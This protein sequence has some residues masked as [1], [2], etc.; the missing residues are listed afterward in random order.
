MAEIELKLTAPVDRLP[1]L[2]AAL[3][4]MSGG[5]T[6]APEALHATYYDTRARDL[7]RQ[8][9]TLRVRRESGGFVQTVKS[10]GRT[11]TKRGEWSDPL[12][13]G[14][15]DLKA[16]ATGRRLRNVLR[17]RVLPQFK[18][19][20]SRTAFIIHAG[21]DTTI[22]A[23]V[24]EGII[25]G[26]GKNAAHDRV[27]EV[28]LELKSGD[29]AALYTTALKLMAIAPLA[30][31]TRSKS[32]RG[33]AL[34]ENET[35]KWMKITPFAID[36]KMSVDDV[37][38]KA[39]LNYLTQC[40]KNTPAVLAD[41][42]EGIHQMRVA[43]RRLRGLLNALKKELPEAAHDWANGRLK[44][45]LQS[46]GPARNWDVFVDEMVGAVAE[47]GALSN[48]SAFLRAANIARMRAHLHARDAIASPAHTTAILELLRWF[49]IR[50]WRDHG[51]ASPSL[52]RRIGKS[53]G[54]LVDRQ[55]RRART[56]GKG[57]EKLSTE[58]RHAFRIAVKSLRY[59]L[60]LFCP[61]LDAKKVRALIKT[62]KPLQE[63]LGHLND[64]ST[65]RELLRDLTQQDASPNVTLVGGVVLGWHEGRMRGQE[66]R[67]CRAV[68]KFR[69]FTP[70]W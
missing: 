46:L 44:R 12:D 2:R 11:L 25:K 56:R 36:P 64:I 70:F 10:A 4:A 47:E 68:E 39:G 29:P 13:D 27:A 49:E 37:L 42:A 55:F 38:R 15:P 40:L 22:E 30:I 17:G 8:G 6:P 3:A 61:A 52:N 1:A 45:V 66:K 43:L 35:P 32:A 31:E 28:E 9:L 21:S 5:H 33:Y 54:A 24:D 50:G 7:A 51:V 18:V 20:V 63:H 57:F 19:D 59:T 53:A 41:S 14:T 62:L 69:A 60:D 58:E 26:P 34:L 67:L 48:A 16:K 23:A 65:A